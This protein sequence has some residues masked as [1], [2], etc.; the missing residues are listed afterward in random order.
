MQPS[1]VRPGAIW[2]ILQIGMQ[3]CSDRQSQQHATDS[4]QRQ[5]NVIGREGALRDARN[6]ACEGER[7]SRGTRETWPKNGDQREPE[8]ARM[9]GS[10]PVWINRREKREK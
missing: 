1:A 5:G 10:R 9:G 6:G 7:M 2:E 8:G 3:R 4:R